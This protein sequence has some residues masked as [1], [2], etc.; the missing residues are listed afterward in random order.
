MFCLQMSDE[1]SSGDGGRG[2]GPGPSKRLKMDPA[3]VQERQ[4]AGLTEGMKQHYYDKD[5]MDFEIRTKTGPIPCHR[6]VL[7]A[8]SP[9]FKGLFQMRIRTVGMSEHSVD[10]SQLEKCAVEQLVEFMYM[11]E[12]KAQVDNVEELVKASRFLLMDNATAL[13][14]QFLL[15]TLTI[16]CCVR[17]YR[18]ASLYNL[19]QLQEKAHEFVLNHFCDLL[20][21]PDFPHLHL[22]DLID[23]LEHDALNVPSEQTVVDA[24]LVW[25]NYD[26]EGREVAA[27]T[28]A[29][30]IRFN[31]CSEEL[32]EALVTDPKYDIIS[33]LR[34]RNLVRNMSRERF[35]PARTTRSKRRTSVAKSLNQ[36]PRYSF[37]SNKLLVIGGRAAEKDSKACNNRDCMYWSRTEQKWQRFTELPVHCVSCRQWR[38]C[39]T[40]GRIFISGGYN[41]N[42]ETG[43]WEGC[44]EVWM[45]EN[46]TWTALPPMLRGRWAH[47]MVI[48]SN[49]LFCFG[50][51]SRKQG[52]YI[53]HLKHNEYLDL[54]R[55]S[56]DIGSST[57][58]CEWKSTKSMKF[59]F[60]NPRVSVFGECIYLLGMLGCPNGFISA[61]Y[62]YNIARRSLSQKAS[63]P[64]AAHN[65]ESIVHGDHIYVFGMEHRDVCMRYAPG[66]DTWEQLSPSIRI[67]DAAPASSVYLDYISPLVYVDGKVVLAKLRRRDKREHTLAVEAYD[68]N[69]DAWTASNI[70][71][72]AAYHNKEVSL[73][74]IEMR[75]DY[76]TP[77]DTT[78]STSATAIVRKAT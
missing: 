1:S 3:A 34:F 31:Y 58:S 70:T 51:K 10:L 64:A 27:H 57:T 76:D 75:V 71:L 26:I 16:P 41:V 50:G 62:E 74:N 68:I 67:P 25:L 23:F 66:T 63:M 13:C 45:Y 15:D 36:R 53:T 14:E 59:N 21:D 12:L 30:T 52:S 42:E 38:V 6:L 69:D 37:T 47:G 46:N 44:N 61:T 29:E 39:G 35:G 73:L 19:L 18:I 4:M 54:S 17:W 56:Q 11:G 8:S 48:A 5:L 9:Y 60:Y 77:H 32:L 65:G 33:S 40:D 72:P 55:L 7:S 49:K 43:F 24:I 28:L 22:S 78:C 20:T 2:G